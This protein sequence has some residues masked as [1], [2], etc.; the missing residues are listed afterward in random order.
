MK[1]I[2]PE[3]LISTYDLT[4]PYV[5]DVRKLRKR[6]DA[7]LEKLHPCF[8][9]QCA[10]DY[11]LRFRRFWNSRD[12][13]HI[14]AVVMDRTQ[15]ATI[16]KR[17]GGCILYLAGSRQY[18]VFSGGIV[19]RRLSYAAACLLFVLA[20][21]MMVRFFSPAEEEGELTAAVSGLIAS[22]PVSV[23][24]PPDSGQPDETAPSEQP[25][26][27]GL[28]LRLHELG[29]RLSAFTWSGNDGLTA[30]KTAGI[31]P[32]QL[33]AVASGFGSVSFGVVSYSD[34]KPEYMVSVSPDD[35]ERLLQRVSAFRGTAGVMAVRQLILENGGIL[36]S[37][38]VSPPSLSGMVPESCWTA[39]AASMSSYFAEPGSPSLSGLSFAREAG[40]IS[41]SVQFAE[42]AED[43]PVRLVPFLLSD[44]TFVFYDAPG[45]PFEAAEVHDGEERVEEL[46][47]TR[48]IGR[49]SRADGSCIVFIHNEDGKIERRIYEN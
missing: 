1:T 21:L 20:V 23:P 9:E 32:E 41:V 46:L 18:P 5:F 24:V 11:R 4:V 28:F 44:M 35:S 30:F 40:D 19:K 17:N 8:P 10:V 42:S 15:L 36:L 39:F 25:D 47:K 37:E 12:G 34:G 3:K 31:Y 26:F 2:I 6:L 38:T 48:E 33:K 16:R 13:L 49:I 45:L 22:P 27:K 29:G 7:E 14:R 43:V